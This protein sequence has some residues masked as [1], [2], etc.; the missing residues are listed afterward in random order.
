[1]EIKQEE[2]SSQGIKIIA[3]DGEKEIGR[4]YLYLMYNDL[5]KNPFGFME[6]V[7]VDDEYRGKGIGTKLVDELIKTA[8]AKDC[9]KLIACSRYTRPKVHDLY[10]KIGFEDWG[11]EFRM[12]M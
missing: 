11:K 9:Y 12:N 4:A 7:F 10:S 2:A 3:M 1:M 6:D 8:Q 5:H